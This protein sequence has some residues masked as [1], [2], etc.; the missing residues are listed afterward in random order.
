MVTFWNLS[1][2][3]ITLQVDGQTHLLVRGQRLKL[4]PPR[5][6]MWRA[7]ADAVQTERL[8]DGVPSL[9]IVIRR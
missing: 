7:G 2:R 8:P 5:Q 6:F 1:A 9:E 4:A 3:D